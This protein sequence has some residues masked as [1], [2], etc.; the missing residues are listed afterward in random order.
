MKPICGLGCVLTSLY[1]PDDIM[2]IMGAF[3]QVI[4]TCLEIEFSCCKAAVGRAKKDKDL[5]FCHQITCNC[6]IPRTCVAGS[7]QV[8]C[9]DQRCAFPPTNDFPCI[10]NALGF[11]CCIKY[12]W[13]GT[14]CGTVGV[15]APELI[16]IS[17]LKDPLSGQGQAATV[18]ATEMQPQYIQEQQ[19]FN[20][21]FGQAQTTSNIVYPQS[22]PPQQ[23]VYVQAPPPQQVVYV[24]QA[25]PS[26][27]YVQP[28]QQVYVQPSPQQVV[29]M[30]P[31]QPQAVY[32]QQQSMYTPTPSN[33]QSTFGQPSD[34]RF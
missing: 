16:K 24:Q 2:R 17:C 33:Q 4:F 5:L 8:C 1:C 20:S 21:Q 19:Q 12:E 15:M 34:K 29:Y 10:L 26:P 14:C 28:S 9:L 27:I 31:P 30:Q 18:A 11:T 7:T 13:S 25:T 6:I 3:G 23:Q 32:V 22:P